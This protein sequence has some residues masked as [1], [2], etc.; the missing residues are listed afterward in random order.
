MRIQEEKDEF[1]GQQGLESLII[2][3]KDVPNADLGK[4]QEFFWSTGAG[5]F[6]HQN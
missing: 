3:A 5:E 2:G 6:D 1:S 4:K